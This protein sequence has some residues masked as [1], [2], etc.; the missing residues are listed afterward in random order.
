M[1]SP[2]K[3]THQ[4]KKKEKEKEKEENKNRNKEEKE[5]ELAELWVIFPI[6][7]IHF[8]SLSFLAR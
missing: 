2:P 6:L 8:S 5:I 3:K 4:K 1:Q 7:T